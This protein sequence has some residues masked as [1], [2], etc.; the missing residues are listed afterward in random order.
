[1]M[2]SSQKIEKTVSFLRSHPSGVLSTVS[3]D[4]KPWGSTIYFAVDDD[5]TIYFTTRVKTQ[6]AKNI[7]DNQ[8]VSL[9]VTNPGSQQTVQ[10]GGKAIPVPAHDIPEVVMKK[11]A[12]IK[13]E[14][15]INW[16]PP[17]TKIDSG[18]YTVLKIEPNFVQFADFSVFKDDIHATYIERII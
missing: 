13:H 8:N 14:K 3:K 9:T 11:I 18:D 6:K 17:I 15:D 1:M 2:S 16:T 12:N 5:L 10:I 7:H 4:S